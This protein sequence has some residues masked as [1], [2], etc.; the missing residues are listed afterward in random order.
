MHICSIVPKSMN[1]RVSTEWES[2]GCEDSKGNSDP[3]TAL[4]SVSLSL[5]SRENTVAGQWGLVRCP[6]WCSYVG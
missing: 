1:E 5:L 4:Q 2:L 3:R 6:K